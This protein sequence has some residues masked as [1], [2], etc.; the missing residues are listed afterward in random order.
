[1]QQ[2][3]ACA[4]IEGPTVDYSRVKRGVVVVIRYDA[5]PT[6]LFRELIVNVGPRV[7]EFGGVMVVLRKD[8]SLEAID[9][10]TMAD[11]GWFH[12]RR[13]PVLPFVL[14]VL[15][16]LLLKVLLEIIS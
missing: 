1:M 2:H 14:G 4:E 16:T 13:V 15:A 12:H 11:N 3:G 8:Q 9:E 7:T 10:R 6:D 5:L